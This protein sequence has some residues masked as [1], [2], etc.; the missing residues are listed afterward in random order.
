MRDQPGG[1]AGAEQRGRYADPLLA[2]WER[3]DPGKGEPGEE[4]GE[5]EKRDERHPAMWGSD[6]GGDV[7]E[8]RPSRRVGE[9]WGQ[10]PAGGGQDEY[11]DETGEEPGAVAHRGCREESSKPADEWVGHGGAPWVPAFRKVH[12]PNHPA[13]AGGPRPAN[14]IRLCDRSSL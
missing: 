7:N 14:F 11:E 2:G 13:Q 3:K 6:L 12:P 4:K 10:E 1:A 5:S 8:H 9:A